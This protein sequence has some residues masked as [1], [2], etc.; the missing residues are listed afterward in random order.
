L[1]AAAGD[2]KIWNNRSEDISGELPPYEE[3]YLSVPMDPLMMAAYRELEDA[4]RKAL[5]APG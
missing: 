4:I 1:D 5:K 3:T 2:A